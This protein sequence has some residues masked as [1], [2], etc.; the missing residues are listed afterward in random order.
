MV[1]LWKGKY[2]IYFLY[3]DSPFCMNHKGVGGTL[4]SRNSSVSLRNEYI[5][6]LEVYVSHVRFN[7]TTSSPTIL[8]WLR[9]TDQ[10]LSKLARGKFFEKMEIVCILIVVVVT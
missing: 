10:G 9:T 3:C 1:I 8:Y 2:A 6:F 4:S 5:S 7:F